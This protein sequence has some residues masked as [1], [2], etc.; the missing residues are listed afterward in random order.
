M[1][2]ASPRLRSVLSEHFSLAI[3][4]ASAQ[5]PRA[6]L[7]SSALYA[8][9]A[10]CARGPL[11]TTIEAP[12]WPD[13]QTR[14]MVHGQ[15]P[16]LAMDECLPF[17]LA[18]SSPG[19][20][21]APSALGRLVNEWR[22]AQAAGCA[23]PALVQHHIG[24]CVCVRCALS[25]SPV[26]FSLGLYVG[27]TRRVTPHGLPPRISIIELR[28]CYWKGIRSLESMGI[29]IP[30]RLYSPRVGK[31]LEGPLRSYFIVIKPTVSL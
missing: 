8:R 15:T 28:E 10:P 16:V 5:R 19:A 9:R 6:K 4:C 17:M 27:R 20:Q 14:C 21:G 1:P 23:A 12:L 31:P 24:A 7:A 29:C 22:R 3:R 18:S 2:P 30:Q 11:R 26:A 25:F 13:G